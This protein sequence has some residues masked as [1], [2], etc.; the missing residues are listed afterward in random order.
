MGGF[1]Y[2]CT[3]ETFESSE[4]KELQIMNITLKQMNK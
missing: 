3:I 4:D 2:F 1:L